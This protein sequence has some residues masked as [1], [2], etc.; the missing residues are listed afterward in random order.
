MLFKVLSTK[1]KF[2]SFCVFNLEQVDLINQI[3]WE[4][5]SEIL[6]HLNLFLQS[7]D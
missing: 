2:K 4:G 1:P 3:S 6:I 5:M 7:Q